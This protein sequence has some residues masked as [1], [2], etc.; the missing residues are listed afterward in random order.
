M[1][2]DDKSVV[3]RLPTDLEPGETPLDWF[4][5]RGYLKDRPLEIPERKGDKDF[6][7]ESQYE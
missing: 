7:R 5:K 6:P 4:R 2:D 3:T 1:K